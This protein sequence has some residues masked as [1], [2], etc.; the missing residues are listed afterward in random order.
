MAQNEKVMNLDGILDLVFER[1]SHLYILY[2]GDNFS[3]CSQCYYPRNKCY[4]HDRPCKIYENLS[5][6]NLYFGKLD[7]IIL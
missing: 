4:G 6:L 1:G 3:D 5:N 7:S 2:V